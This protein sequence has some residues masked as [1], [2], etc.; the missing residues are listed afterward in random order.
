M[1]TTSAAVITIHTNFHPVLI[2][3]PPIRTELY[4]HPNTF[5]YDT[6]LLVK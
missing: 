2:L 6:M 4:F 5:S 1:T 3:L